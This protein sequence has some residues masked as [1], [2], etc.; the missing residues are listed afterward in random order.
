M[1]FLFSRTLQ[2]GVAPQES[3]CLF[4]WDKGNCRL[5]AFMPM[6]VEEVEEGRSAKASLYDLLRMNIIRRASITPISTSNPDPESA[7]EIRIN[8]LADENAE[9]HLHALL[10]AIDYRDKE[11][12]GTAVWR[13]S[14]TRVASRPADAVF[15][16][17]GILGVDLDPLKFDP[18][19]RQA[20]TTALMQALLDKGE[21]AEWLGAAP[22][23]PR[24]L[25]LP[26][27]P[28]F[29]TAQGGKAVIKVIDS[30]QEAPTYRPVSEV[31]GDTWW[32]HLDAPRGSML[33]DGT[34]T[35]TA[36]V[37]AVRKSPT[38]TDAADPERE[39]YASN[40][41]VDKAWSVAN[42]DKE[43]PFA[44]CLGKK[45]RYTNAAA[46]MRH[47]PW[48][49]LVMLVE[50][51]SSEGEFRCLGY[52]SVT[53]EVA[54]MTGWHEREIKLPPTTVQVIWKA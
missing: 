30:E 18:K 17:M 2:E 20:A 53:Q 26:Y 9:S 8:I 28:E 43:P 36:R 5:Q 23:L 6:L 1:F 52:A 24:N 42:G 10:G 27:L 40:S 14:L 45:E 29:P 32:R 19:D 37:I 15:S 47:D 49:W 11:G 34:L 25:S 7:E 54:D 4:A 21:R 22:D 51:W 38:G 50:R 48:L 44:V 13:A 39:I 31:M 46:P 3:T 33:D 12:L 41:L 16:I 35:F